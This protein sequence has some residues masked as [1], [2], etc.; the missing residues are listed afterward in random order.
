MKEKNNRKG[1][2]MSFNSKDFKGFTFRSGPSKSKV[3]QNSSFWWNNN[4][5]DTN[6]DEFLGLDT[7]TKKGKDLVALA[8]YRRAIS[9]FVNIVTEMNIPVSF[10]N[11][12]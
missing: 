11:N 12:D 9:N 8:G 1:K 7:T 10:N 6:V 5:D 2:F 3:K 4:D